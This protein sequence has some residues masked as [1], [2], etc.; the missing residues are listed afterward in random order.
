MN[1]Q[2]HI[3]RLDKLLQTILSPRLLRAFIYT[4][5]LSGAE[6]RYILG[7]DLASAVDIG[8][9]RGQFSLAVRR[10]APEAEVVAF[11]PL[12]RPASVFCKVFKD[13]SS[14]ILH[15]TAIGPETGEATIH[16]S[17]ADDSSS[18]LP[19]SKAQQRLFPGT[20][21]ISTV[22]IPVGRLA[23]FVAP[24]EI[25]HPALL[26][27]DVQGYEL[28]VLEGCQDLIECFSQ[29]YVECSFVELY[30]GQA[31]AHEIIAWLQRKKFYLKGIYNL[32]YDKQGQ[33]V[34]GD[35]LFEKD[36][37]KTLKS[38]LPNSH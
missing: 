4:R 6:H 37:G 24:K 23:D 10:W 36:N 38:T 34:Q 29:V 2:L 22:T 26:K 5:V 12:D 7:R 28:A 1:F 32:Y 33:A 21:E 31:F 3:T 13:D 8:A 16:V 11:E 9:N 20:G 15:K 18:L 19:I 17:D 14:V 25:V 27:I 35:F 30:T